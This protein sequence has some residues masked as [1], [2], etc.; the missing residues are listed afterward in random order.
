[1]PSG[2]EG[3]PGRIIVTGASKGIGAAI[4]GELVSRGFGVVALSR[5][6]GGPHGEQLACDMTDEA[7]VRDV[8]GRI[9]ASGPVSGLVNNAGL[10]LS[11]P[12]AELPTEEYRKVMALNADAVMIAAREVYPHLVSAGGGTIINI[13]SF[14]DKLGVPA[15]LAYCASK[16]AVAAMT[17]C[18]AVEWAGDGVKVMNVAPGYIETD[19]NRDFLARDSVRNWLSKRVPMGRAGTPDEVARLVAALFVEDIAYL[20]GE[21]VYIDGGHGMNH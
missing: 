5:S 4:A 2:S 3:E 19:L 8:F 1:M 16:A 14:F 10:H 11:S 9:A 7:N 21:T 6:G 20:T 15:N 18:M 17:R 13:G 12:T